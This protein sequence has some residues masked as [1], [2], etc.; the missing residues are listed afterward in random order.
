MYTIVALN[1]EK[2]AKEEIRIALDHEPTRKKTIYELDSYVS[3]GPSTT[4]LLKGTSEA[5][6]SGIRYSTS[7]V[8]LSG[9]N[10]IIDN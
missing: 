2:E 7:K 9:Q 5:T 8:F 1:W 10:I 3:S 6:I 4:N